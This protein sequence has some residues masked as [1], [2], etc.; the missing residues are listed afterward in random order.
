MMHFTNS[1]FTP[2]P[3]LALIG[4]ASLHDHVATALP[5][6]PLAVDVYAVRQH[7]FTSPNL[8]QP[9]NARKP[10]SANTTNSAY[11]TTSKGNTNIIEGP[12]LNA[13]IINTTATSLPNIDESRQT[14]VNGW[15]L[16]CPA[17]FT[18]CATADGQSW[19]CIDTET[20]LTQCESSLVAVRK[21][22]S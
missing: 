3:L 1:L 14:Y 21:V 12:Q 4:L 15:S 11:G 9:K 18:P 17:G 8:F 13:Q 20:S 5:I 2:V 22:L 16:D 6:A 10:L 19:E 7:P